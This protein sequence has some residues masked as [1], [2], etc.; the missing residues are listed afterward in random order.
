MKAIKVIFIFVILYFFYF[1]YSSMI[2]L[3]DFL[4]FNQLYLKYVLYGLIVTLVVFYLIYPLIKYIRRPSIKQLKLYMSDDKYTRKLIKYANKKFNVKIESKDE[5]RLILHKEVDRFEP[6]IKK[7]AQQTTVTVMVSPNSFIDGISI[8]LSNSKMMFELSSILGFRYDFKNLGKMYF[9]IL[10]VASATGLLEEF[11]DTIEAIIEE[12]AEEFSELIAEETGKSV[13]QSIPFF[14]V[15]VNSMSPILQAAGNYAFIHYSGHNFKYTL[16]NIIDD[17][18]LTE[19][20]IKRKAR[21]RARV[22]KYTYIKDMSGRIVS[23]TGKKLVSLNP[24]KKKEE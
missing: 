23:G 12:L 21:K 10:S 20:E 22:L 19:K 17:E 2:E 14:S 18:N 16:L 9:S 13:S 24:F 3:V 1:A 7:Y 11:D 8:L 4:S 6:I 15:A 5:L